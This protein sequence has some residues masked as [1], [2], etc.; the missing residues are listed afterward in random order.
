MLR[1]R[2]QLATTGFTAKPCLG[3]PVLKQKYSLY[4][5][6][7]LKVNKS[8]EESLLLRCFSLHHD[9]NINREMSLIIGY[10]SDHQHLLEK[11]LFNKKAVLNIRRNSVGMVLFY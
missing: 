11:N 3:Q 4:E 8:S 7:L 10:C 6:L 9:F 1:L 5:V 2:S